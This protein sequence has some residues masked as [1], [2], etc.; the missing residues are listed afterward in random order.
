MFGNLSSDVRV[1]SDRV[2]TVTT[3][4]PAAFP[5]FARP[6]CVCSAL[7]PGS[8]LSGQ[9]SLEQKSGESGLAMLNMAEELQA[10]KKLVAATQAKL[11][12]LHQLSSK[13]LAAKKQCTCGAQAAAGTGAAEGAPPAAA[14]AAVPGADAAAAGSPEGTGSS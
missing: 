4:I 14:A 7:W 5:P 12:K 1:S 10:Q 6:V 9:A 3:H 13:L 2:V 11:E 8:P